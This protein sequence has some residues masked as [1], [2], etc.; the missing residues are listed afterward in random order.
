[1]NATKQP[2]YKVQHY[3]N[4][5]HVEQKSIIITISSI[6]TIVITETENQPSPYQHL[7]L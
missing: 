5:H 7:T 4:S 6:M 3:D 2:P 1:M